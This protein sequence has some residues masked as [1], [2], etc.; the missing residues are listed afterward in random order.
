MAQSILDRN[1]L[2]SRSYLDEAKLDRKSLSPM[3]LVLYVI[4]SSQ[5]IT[6]QLQ[7]QLI[8]GRGS[9]AYHPDIDLSPLDGIKYG[10]SRQHAV[11]IYDGASLFIED[12]QS[13]NGTRIN[14]FKLEPGESYSLHN[15]DEL[16]IGRLRVV[17][18]LVRAPG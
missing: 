9:T 7:D 13:T 1:S 2:R 6:A 10:I 11:F 5:V 16:E 3:R 8:V 14:G 4:G 18:R 17:V 12:L 15:D